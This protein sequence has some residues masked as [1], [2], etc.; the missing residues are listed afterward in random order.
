MTS[1]RVLI[2]APYMLA[3]ID[4][5][6]G[7]FERLG[8]ALSLADVR[9]RL[10]EYELLPLVGDIDGTICGDDRITARVL[11]VATPR[12]RVISKWGTGIDSIDLEAARRL[13]VRVCN[14]PELS[15]IPWRKIGRAHV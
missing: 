12:L 7:R 2:S 11:E 15:P 8:I 3:V 1:F 13:G 4:R 5:F 14:T 10:E 6:R 9:E